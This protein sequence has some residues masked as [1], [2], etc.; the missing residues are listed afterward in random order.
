MILHR[1]DEQLRDL[2]SLVDAH[3]DNA[4]A[5]ATAVSDE[6]LVLKQARS[7]LAVVNTQHAA[8]SGDLSRLEAAISALERDPHDADIAMQALSGWVGPAEEDPSV[9]ATSLART[10]VIRIHSDLLLALLS[11]DET[12]A[13]RKHLARP[14]FERLRWATG[15]YLVCGACALLG[16]GLQILN[17]AWRPNSP[18]DQDG[19][20]RRW[21]DDRLHHHTLNSPIDY[22]GPGF[23][24]GLHRVRTRGHDLARFFEAVDQTARGEFAGVRWSYGTAAEVIQAANQYGT[25]Y[26]PMSW[27]AAFVNVTV[28]LFGDFFSAHSLPLP[29]SSV[30]YEN[31]RR[32]LRKFVHDLYENGFN[33][34][35]VSLGALEVL[36]A[37]L[38]IEVWLWLQYGKSRH[39]DPVQMKR[40]EMRAAVMGFLS[41]ANIAGC[42]L[43]ENPFLLDIPVLIAAVDSAIR[44]L[45]LR[46]KSASWVF[47]EIRNLDELFSEWNSLASLTGT[48]AAK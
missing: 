30:V 22:Q 45:G 23:G 15:D 39:D 28:H 44:L 11:E 37:H 16:L 27:L 3:N 42:A 12:A 7:R 26:P 47:K 10:G 9:P 6:R 46:A 5:I 14:T 29:L 13:L 21:F 25:T 17:Y 40:Y 24:G 32:E 18:I 4:W 19:G 41:G 48:T 1:Y 20:L 33:L 31:A 2:T 34:R 36:L 38:A 35:H 43:F 8:F